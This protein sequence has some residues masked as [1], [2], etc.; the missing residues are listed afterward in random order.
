MNWFNDQDIP[1][2][3]F[4]FWAESQVYHASTD[5]P[6]RIDRRSV[7]HQGSY[8]LELTKHF[9]NQNLI[10]NETATGDAIYFSL[11]PGVLINYPAAW[12]IP[13]GE[14]TGILLVILTVFGV[15]SKR[16]TLRGVLKGLGGFLLS[17]VAS[18]GLATGIW[19]GLP[20]CTV[21]TRPC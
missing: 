13:L 14:L 19:M 1:G 6:Q 15:R 7:Q 11:F 21:N 3:N 10:S 8:A 16:I 4:G 9:G 20:N 2:M 18:S 17:L 12:A 5:T